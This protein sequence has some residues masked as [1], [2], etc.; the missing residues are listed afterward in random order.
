VE[1]RPRAVDLHVEELV[2]DGVD[3][4][5]E[6]QFTDS[7][8]G[9]L[10][11]ALAEGLRSSASRRHLDGAATAGSGSAALGRSAARAVL[12]RLRAQPQS[13]SS[14]VFGDGAVTQ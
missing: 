9:E 11:R 2:V 10:T 14:G 5:D 1:L 3:G 4:F 7:F 13:G 8:R 6:L 12:D